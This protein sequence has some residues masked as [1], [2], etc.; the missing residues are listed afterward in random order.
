LLKINN[1]EQINN[2]IRENEMVILYFSNKVCGACEVIKDKVDK[3]LEIYTKVNGIEMDGE[4][5]IE[6]AAM[7][8]V[9]SFPL[10]ILYVNGK[11]SMRVGRNVNLLELENTI[12][13]YYEMLF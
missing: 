6:L 12:K 3:I 5:N 10:L 2:A 9:F 1:E 4:E 7:N 11:E 8:N 13:R